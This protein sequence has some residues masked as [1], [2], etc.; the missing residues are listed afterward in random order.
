MIP[1]FKKKI[2]RA[3]LI[4]SFSLKNEFITAILEIIAVQHLHFFV[5]NEMFPS[6]N[7]LLGF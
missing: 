5:F 1:T 4:L 2:S 6:L 3:I 7:T